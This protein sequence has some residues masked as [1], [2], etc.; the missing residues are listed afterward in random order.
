MLCTEFG[1]LENFVIILNF[2][3][4]DQITDIPFPFNGIWKDVLNDN[5]VY[6]ATEGQLRN[7]KINSNWGR[8]LYT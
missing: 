1:Q 5:R 8:I 7:Q 2:S 4:T 6:T 3:A